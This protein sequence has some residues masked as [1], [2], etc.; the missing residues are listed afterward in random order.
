MKLNS[1]HDLYIHE[2][3][4][5]YSAEHQIIKALPKM[6]EQ[7]STDQ[8]RAAFEEHLQQTHEHV[9]RL[10]RIFQRLNESPKGSKCQG[11]EG[12]I[13]EGEDLMDEDAPESVCDAALIESAQ[14]VEHYE[15]S[16]YGTVRTW[17]QQ[18]GYSEDA[19]LLEQTLKEEEMTDK[20]LT[21]I[22]ETQ[23]NTQ[24]TR[25]AR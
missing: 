23:V 13:D 14:K 8:L 20:K 5:L 15:M 24:A 16:G 22:A 12:I 7:A 21:R 2:L 17:A 11:I 19:G 18:L 10:V 9:S 25:S 4:D 3:Q 6:A 1:L